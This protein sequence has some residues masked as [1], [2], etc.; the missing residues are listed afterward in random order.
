MIPTMTLKNNHVRF[1]VSLIGPGEGR[2]TTHLLKCVLL[3]STSQTDWKQSS[4]I[5]FWHIFWYFF[6]H[7]FWH[8]FWHAFWQ[9][10]W[11]YLWHI[12]RHALWHIFCHSFS[13]AW[14]TQVLTTLN[15]HDRCCGPA[16]NTGLP[17]LRLRSGTQHWPPRIA[18]EVRHATLT[19]HDLGWGWARNAGLTCLRLRSGTQHWPPRIAV[20]VRGPTHTLG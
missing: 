13:H 11:Q 3:L 18:V 2:Y 4:D 6:W 16:R 12:F 7:S 9:I 20:E 17:G 5:P 15:A 8:I 1:Y 14:C 10:F 19:S